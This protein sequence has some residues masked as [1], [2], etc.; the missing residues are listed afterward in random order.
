[1]KYLDK[2]GI[3][4][5]WVK[6]TRSEGRMR[7]AHMEK[8]KE[9]IQQLYGEG[10]V[11]TLEEAE[12]LFHV[13][14]FINW[15]AHIDLKKDHSIDE[16]TLLKWVEEV[17]DWP[18]YVVVA[19]WYCIRNPIMH[20][21][22]TSPFSDFERKSPDGK[23][24]LYAGFHPNMKSDP[25]VFEEGFSALLNPIEE[26]KLDVTFFY[27]G[28]HRKLEQMLSQVVSN[29][30]DLDESKVSTLYKIN[31]KLLPLYY[32]SVEAEPDEGE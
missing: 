6:S 27:A 18:D 7:L 9:L 4:E 30:K 10:R 16:K 3:K 17:M 8:K 2:E 24:K 11:P 15:L 21:G 28:V 1:M 14:T 32:S 29:I 5:T 25:Q 22:R 26:G 12:M 20:Q 13:F 31:R 23:Y 19:F